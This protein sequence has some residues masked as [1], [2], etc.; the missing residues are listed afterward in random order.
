[1]A[2]S[3][4]PRPFPS[5]ALVSLAASSQLYEGEGEEQEEEEEEE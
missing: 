3:R 2:A 5:A 1:M 4:P